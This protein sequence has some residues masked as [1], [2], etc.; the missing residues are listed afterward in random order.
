MYEKV[1]F[2]I[3]LSILFLKC[4]NFAFFFRNTEVYPETNYTLLFTE[5][6]KC[7]DCSSK[8]DDQLKSAAH[9]ADRI[10]K[11]NNKESITCKHWL[12]SKLWFIFENCSLKFLVRIFSEHI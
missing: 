4:L 12:K 9:E 7:G 11:T 10:F 5:L 8:S 3:Y 1:F 2:A 6:E